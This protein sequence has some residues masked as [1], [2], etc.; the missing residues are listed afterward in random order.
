MKQTIKKFYL[1]FFKRKEFI[2]LG[3]KGTCKQCGECCKNLLSL[4][5]RCP[6]LTKHNK[7]RLHK[8]KPLFC[9]LTPIRIGMRNPKDCAYLEDIKENHEE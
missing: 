9:K 6:F 7:C 2:K 3:L 5:L 4:G 1:Y 8:H